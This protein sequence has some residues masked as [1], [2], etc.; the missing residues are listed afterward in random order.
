LDPLGLAIVGERL[1]DWILPGMTARMSRPRFLT[2]IALSAAVC[3]GLQDTIASDGITPA[4]LV[5]EWLMVEGF[6]RTAD[7]ADVQRT[8]GIEKARN[9]RRTDLRMS[10]RTYLK[11]PTVFGFHGVY[12]RLARN[13]GIIDQDDILLENGY[14]LLKTW[15]REQG[16]DGFLESTIAGLPGENLRQHLR[17]AVT[18]GLTAGYSNRS[19]GWKGW[20][21]FAQ[22]LVPARIGTIES[23]L[24]RSFLVD[25]KA[26]TRGEVF[27][28]VEEPENFASAEG[29]HEADLIRCLL[30]QASTELAQRFRA[31][32]AYEE[33]CLLLETSFEW[34]RWLS[35]RSGTR[36]I[37]RQEFAAEPAVAQ[38]VDSLQARLIAAEQ[39]L[40]AAPFQVQSEFAQLAHYFDTV[41]DAESFL[42]GLLHR[43]GEVQKAKPPEGKRSWFEQA[44][45]GGIFVRIPYRLEQPPSEREWW[46]RPYRLV[47]VYSFCSDLKGK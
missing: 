14:L 4:Y 12:R 15:E 39:A 32:I 43:H 40:G 27:R 36:A 8:P 18:D 46:S 33:F 11:A 7:R 26:D 23:Q 24:L 31:I 29:N 34:L 44:D 22:R 47:A 25:V 2:A 5:F 3:E 6:A 20:Q 1:A 10:A 30:P 17:S 9:C 19:G 45:N 42:E 38:C 41:Q 16:L 21:F 35:S 28:L 13:I 37:T